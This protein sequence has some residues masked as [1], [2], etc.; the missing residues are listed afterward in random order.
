MTEYSDYEK[1]K[2][3]GQVCLTFSVST[4]KVFGEAVCSKFPFQVPS[5]QCQL[6]HSD[7]MNH[8]FVYII[9]NLKS[10]EN[11]RHKA[12]TAPLGHPDRGGECGTESLS[13][14]SHRKVFL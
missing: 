9:E 14:Q 3:V 4:D 11:T 8:W 10:C 7:P 13:H 12:P 5:H 6:P 2:A 1:N